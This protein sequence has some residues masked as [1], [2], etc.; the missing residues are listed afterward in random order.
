MSRAG[1]QVLDSLDDRALWWV[2]AN[3]GALSINTPK[4]AFLRTPPSHLAV[5]VGN[6]AL[7]RLAE[8]LTL[9]ARRR[10]A[11][12]NIEVNVH[13]CAPRPDHRETD[14]D[15]AA[16]P[17]PLRER[18]EAAL[19]HHRRDVLVIVRELWSG[20]VAPLGEVATHLGSRRTGNK[21]CVSGI[22][23]DLFGDGPS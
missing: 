5:A 8:V 11:G 21:L 18:A 12:E 20:F 2:L 23:S 7:D 13:L 6:A 14:G 19:A 22:A 9:A 15:V 10:E 4:N 17:V 3:C 16:R 1:E